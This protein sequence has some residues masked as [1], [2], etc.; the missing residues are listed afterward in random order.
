MTDNRI[1]Y[2]PAPTTDTLIRQ[3]RRLLAAL[4][5]TQH[6]LE[7]FVSDLEHT[8]KPD[9][10]GESGGREQPKRTG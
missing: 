10:P 6:E 5:A 1:P 2:V 3:S 4:A 8:S 7:R 9:D